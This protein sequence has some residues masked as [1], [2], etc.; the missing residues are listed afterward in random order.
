[1]KRGVVVGA[2]VD[3]VVEED[4]KVVVIAGVD[5]EVVWTG[6][7]D[8][9]VDVDELATEMLV[10]ETGGTF[11]D[12]VAV[13]EVDVAF[14][15]VVMIVGEVCTS[16]VPGIVPDG[17]ATVDVIGAVIV[18]VPVYGTVIVTKGPRVEVVVLIAI[19]VED[20]GDCP[21]EEDVM[22]VLVVLCCA[23]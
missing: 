1:M 6:E 12:V 15:L 14:V 8:V 22:S 4:R 19:A 3:V 23:V 11:V 2:A 9:E 18:P 20:E 5:E 21:V 10:E 16:T 17:F 7:L 13:E